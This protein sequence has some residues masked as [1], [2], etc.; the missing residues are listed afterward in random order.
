MDL[1]KMSLPA[2]L[3]E[4][5]F[6]NSGIHKVIIQDAQGVNH[7]LSR[8]YAMWNKPRP[9][10]STIDMETASKLSSACEKKHLY[11]EIATTAESGWDFSSRWMRDGSD[12]T[13]LATTSVLPVDLNAFI[14][15]VRF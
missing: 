5:E 9:E 8:Y 13:T 15:K 7:S 11:R 1:I 12:L 4:H 10:S 2:L 6:W 14:L 3:K